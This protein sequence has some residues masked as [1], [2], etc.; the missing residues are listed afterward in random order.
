MR[1][2]SARWTDNSM[3]DLLKRIRPIWWLRLGLGGVY[4]YTSTDLIL[5]PTGWYWAVRPLPQ[6]IQTI[7]EDIG[8]NT[9]LRVQGAG[10]LL[11]AF[12]L[13]AW[14]L[15]PR[16][17]AIASLLVALQ[18][19]LILIFVGLTLGTFRD[20]GL[21]GAALALSALLYKQETHGT[22]HA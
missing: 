12:V 18:M 21:L 11:I 10:E 6:F 17:V 1:F 13:L 7:I 14:F 22:E 3:E 4:L 5:H 8:I 19:A 16:V 20:V 15:Q 9:Y 2:G